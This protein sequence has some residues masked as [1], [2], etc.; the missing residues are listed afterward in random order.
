MYIF[1]ITFL[2]VI[3]IVITIIIEKVHETDD[4][5]PPSWMSGMAFG[6]LR[7]IMRFQKHFI[8]PAKSLSAEQSLANLT[9]TEFQGINCTDNF[10]ENNYARQLENVDEE[11]K[12]R[13]KYQYYQAF[14]GLARK[15]DRIFTVVLVVIVV[16][17]TLGLFMI[18]Y[19]NRN[20]MIEPLDYM[21][22][23]QYATDIYDDIYGYCMYSE[24]DTSYC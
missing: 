13:L 21:R 14:R 12:C 2:T 11:M 8:R 7:L 3:S 9:G 1:I 6:S 24:Y 20:T 15:L 5:A 23:V 4:R 18:L 19:V 10:D 16:F 22:E 17:L